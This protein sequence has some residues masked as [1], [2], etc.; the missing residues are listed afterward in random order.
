M[1]SS[2]NSAQLGTVQRDTSEQSQTHPKQGG[3]S[4]VLKLD[5]SDL[6]ASSGLAMVSLN[7]GPDASSQDGLS[8]NH[9]MTEDTIL[10]CAG[11]GVLVGTDTPACSVLGIVLSL[12]Q[13]VQ[14]HVKSIRTAFVKQ[15]LAHGVSR[16]HILLCISPS[17]LAE[18][19]PLSVVYLPGT[20]PLQNDLE[21]AFCGK[22][23]CNQLVPFP[24]W[25]CTRDQISLE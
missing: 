11:N 8:K 10:F 18:W 22:H 1:D 13:K 25:P 2:I 5:P 19:A 16:P 4:K 20:I 17:T 15:Q 21:L 6:Q 7:L 12:Q 24:C 9:H 3:A 14:V 23:C